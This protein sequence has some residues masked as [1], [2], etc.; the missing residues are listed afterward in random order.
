MTQKEYSIPEW[1]ATRNDIAFVLF[2]MTIITSYILYRNMAIELDWEHEEKSYVTMYSDI[3]YMLLLATILFF[4]GNYGK[5]FDYWTLIGIIIGLF[6]FG[7]LG[8]LNFMKNSLASYETWSDEALFVYLTGLI[9]VI[10]FAGYHVFLAYE[11]NI[12][13]QY[14]VAMLIPI[15]SAITA[16]KIRTWDEKPTKFHPHHWFIFYV[17][18]FFTRFDT[19]PSKLTSGLCIGIFVHGLASHG[20]DR[21]FY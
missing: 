4:F 2:M 19:I 3:S 16:Y 20:A 14:L 12:L 6:G 13:V 18:A 15:T 7:Y 21:A 17:L 9:L 8:E 10:A 5:T 11:E 1:L